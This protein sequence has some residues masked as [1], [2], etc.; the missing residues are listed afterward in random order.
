[1]W[2]EWGD[3]CALWG[4]VRGGNAARFGVRGDGASVA[5]EL[6]LARVR[7][8]SAS[9]MGFPEEVRWAGRWMDGTQ[10]RCGRSILV[11][12]FRHVVLS[13]LPTGKVAERLER[14]AA[15]DGA[16]DLTTAGRAARAQD[17]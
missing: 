17:E 5:A 8:N 9:L 1:M 7:P 10:G 2:N 11:G 16:G 12:D 15:P 3:A 14:E 6:V 13:A 4:P